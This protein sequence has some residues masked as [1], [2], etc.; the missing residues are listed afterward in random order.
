MLRHESQWFDSVCRL[1]F[2]RVLFRVFVK[3]ELNKI[4]LFHI[5]IRSVRYRPGHQPSLAKRA[6][7]CPAEAFGEGGPCTASFGWQ[8]TFAL[9]GCAWRSHARP[10][11]RSVSA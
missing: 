4:T 7:G 5:V 2:L 3:T 9:A 6:Q 11:R 10:Q 1:F 8:A